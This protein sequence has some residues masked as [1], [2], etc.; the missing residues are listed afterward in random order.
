[1]K[2]RNYLILFIFSYF[3]YRPLEANPLGD[4]E[5]IFKITQ[6]EF[7]TVVLELNLAKAQLNE[8][9]QKLF[10]VSSE[11]AS[12]AT[13]NSQ[14]LLLNESLRKKIGTLE[15]QLRLEKKQKDQITDQ[16]PQT[17]SSSQHESQ[18]LPDRLESNFKKN[19][20]PIIN[21]LQSIVAEKDQEIKYL[22]SI[23]SSSKIQSMTS[24]PEQFQPIER[25]SINNSFPAKHSFLA[26]GE[27]HQ[28]NDH[29]SR[30]S[31]ISHMRKQESVD[32][33]PHPKNSYFSSYN[34]LQLDPF[35]ENISAPLKHVSIPEELIDRFQEHRLEPQKNSCFSSNQIYPFNEQRSRI[36]LM[37]ERES[38]NNSPHPKYSAP[39]SNQ[40]L[41]SD[42]LKGNSS[43]P[44]KHL[45]LQSN[46]IHLFQEERSEPQKISD[47]S[48]HNR[49]QLDAF[50]Q[51]SSAPLKNSSLQGELINRVPEHGLEAQKI[52]DFS[53]HKMSQFNDHRSRQSIISS[54]NKSPN[55][56]HSSFLS[57]Q[58]YNLHGKKEDL[59]LIS[60]NS[61]LNRF[62]EKEKKE[63]NEE[64]PSQER[65]KKLQAEYNSKC[66]D[67]EFLLE[68]NDE[69][70]ESFHEL[71]E[72]YEKK[73]L[74]YNKIFSI[75]K[76]LSI[77][78]DD[79]RTSNNNSK[80]EVIKIKK[81][82]NIQYNDLVKDYDIL[83]EENIK[84]KLL[85][86]SEDKKNNTIQAEFADANKILK[87]QKNDLEIKFNDLLEK[88]E[89]LSQNYYNQEMLYQGQYKHLREET[90]LNEKYMLQKYDEHEQEKQFFLDTIN[91]LKLFFD[92]T[93]GWIDEKMDEYDS[94]VDEYLLKIC[95]ASLENRDFK[96]LEEL[97][98]LSLNLRM[99]FK[100]RFD[101]ESIENLF[102]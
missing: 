88:Y 18:S 101:E 87:K 36:S 93:V 57:N 1:M 67:Y 68:Q 92:N 38:I 98:K 64:S 41:Q 23:I 56:K 19:I 50:K 25:E 2:K 81:E 40:I 44:L 29:G 97:E 17:L 89:N 94:L 65:I 59:S 30:Q 43:A 31:I 4:N 10:Q 74:E 28:F 83:F 84:L 63:S 21:T 61:E 11:K 100:S 39:S 80:K 42:E 58:Q 53:I 86:N 102:P 35:K 85:L 91:N 49:S 77:D 62:V 15:M 72:K 96:S 24:I 82:F 45:S 51:N 99:T 3:I 47:F 60:E 90:D 66:R 5:E 6:S 13:A 33:S 52:S 8:L 95:K 37:R 9:Q 55:Q 16:Q 73:I 26:E 22:K 54:V 70:I 48:I 34:R 78:Y 69:V 14:L 71:K 7:N 75:Y 20:S 76:N 27:I 79:L 12:L 46:L 32:N